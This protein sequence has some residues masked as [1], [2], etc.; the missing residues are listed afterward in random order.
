MLREACGRQK[1][2]TYEL[3][4]LSFNYP[5]IVG[6]PMDSRVRLESVR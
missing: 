2:I 6:L 3:H 5:A 4:N 1:L